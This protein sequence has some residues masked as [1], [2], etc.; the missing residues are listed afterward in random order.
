MCLCV[1]SAFSARSNGTLDK[2]CSPSERILFAV[3]SIHRVT[4]APAGPPFFLAS[5]PPVVYLPLDGDALVS[6]NLWGFTPAVFDLLRQAFADFLRSGDLV[7]REF[8]LPT[9]IQPT[10][11]AACE[12]ALFRDSVVVTGDARLLVDM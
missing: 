4:S 5:H 11:K 6:M 12:A 1:V 3:C 8:L 9:I 2:P 7:K 10:C